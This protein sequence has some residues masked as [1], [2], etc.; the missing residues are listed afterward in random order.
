VGADE[1]V[2]RSE[3]GRSDCKSVRERY[4]TSALLPPSQPQL[5]RARQ[6]AFW[7]W[8]PAALCL[9]ASLLVGHWV[10]L[11]VPAP[12]APDL[13]AGL[14]ELR[15][16]HGD[17]DAWMAVHV[18]YAACSCSRRVVDH[19]VDDPRPDGVRDKI[20]LVGST[21]EIEQRL[22]SST[23]TIIRTTPTEL[24]EHYE[25]ESAPMLVVV[26]PAGVVRYRGGYTERK[27]SLA[28][29]DIAIIERLRDDDTVGELPLYGCAVSKRLQNLL[30]PLGLRARAL[31]AAQE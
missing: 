12:D 2:G 6:L 16:E 21:P 3:S 23:A 13:V 11:P 7:L 20:L 15:T 27:Q 24:A 26:D 30:D 1:M 14:A 31:A 19:L 8:A 28:I 25:I 22:A 18:L 17:R 4:G 10:T 29:Q 5:R 9:C